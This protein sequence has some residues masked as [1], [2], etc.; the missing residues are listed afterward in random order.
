M[1]STIKNQSSFSKFYSFSWQ[2]WLTI[3]SLLPRSHPDLEPN[4]TSS[5]NIF[6]PHFI[7]SSVVIVIVRPLIKISSNPI[8]NK[9]FYWL[10][11]SF[12]IMQAPSFSSYNWW[13][14]WFYEKIWNITTRNVFHTRAFT[15]QITEIF[16]T[17]YL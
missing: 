5:G 3:V 4:F 8:N 10:L 14:V 15:R 11:L 9:Y 12:I 16:Y 2:N 6:R 13:T 17:C 1:I 7:T